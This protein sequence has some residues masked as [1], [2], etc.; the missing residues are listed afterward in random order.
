VQ[1]LIYLVAAALA[2]PWKDDRMEAVALFEPIRRCYENAA[3][4][5]TLNNN[6]L[7]IM[8]AHLRCARSWQAAFSLQG[9]MGEFDTAGI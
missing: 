7:A 5:F 2:A 1:L 3:R 6:L 4:R 8:M 9:L